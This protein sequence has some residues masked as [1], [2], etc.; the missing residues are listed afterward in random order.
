MQLH[1]ALAP[2]VT[3]SSVANGLALFSEAVRIRNVERGGS[4]ASRLDETQPATSNAMKTAVLIGTSCLLGSRH[5]LM[6]ACSKGVLSRIFVLRCIGALGTTMQFPEPRTR[7][8]Y[9]SPWRVWPSLQWRP[10]QMLH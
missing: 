7:L 3:I 6:L 1:H 9:S 10:V 8:R 5:F 2:P 4:Y